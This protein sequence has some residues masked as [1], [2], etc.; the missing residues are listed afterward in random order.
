[1][2]AN[3]T[4]LYLP[5]LSTPHGYH[6]FQN[7]LTY[8]DVN[9]IQLD[10]FY[11]RAFPH[12]ICIEKVTDLTLQKQGIDTKVF[13]KNGKVLYFDEKKRKKDYGDILLEEYSDFDRRKLGW[14]SG[15]KQT[16]Y[17]TYIVRPSRMAYFL[18]FLLLQRAWLTHYHEWLKNY[19]R[20][21][22]PNKT[23]RTS[24]IP[25][26]TEVLFKAIF[27]CAKF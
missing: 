4:Q 21:F 1:M 6:D 5:G 10:F 19:G 14:L 3:S 22:A 16:D 11:K 20:E 15:E 9:L 18:P 2:L 7:Q 26:P 12:A 8:S 23:Y 24:N 25:V 13:L 17:I 27:E